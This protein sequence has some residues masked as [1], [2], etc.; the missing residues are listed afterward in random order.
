MR[1]ILLPLLSVTLLSA[2]SGGEVKSALGLK[3]RSPDE[4]MVMSRPALTVPPAFDLP[5]PSV[6]SGPAAQSPQNAAK[7][8]AVVFG[9]PSATP[10]KTEAKPEK[11][12]GKSGNAEQLF[13][14]KAGAD[15]SSLTDIRSKLEDDQR[16]A[17]EA[18]GRL[19]EEEQN[20]FFNRMLEPIRLGDKPDP[21]VNPEKE[22]ERLKSNM[23]EGLP[24]NEGDVETIQPKRES[25]I[26]KIF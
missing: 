17:D 21:I 4:F 20:G 13:L 25:V 9:E 23:E 12:T 5:E 24:A 10:A 26:D 18:A 2:C 7:A 22:K 1:K 6:S 14:K 11:K 3:K 8:Q 19:A 16:A 15:D